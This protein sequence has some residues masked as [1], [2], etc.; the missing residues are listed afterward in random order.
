MA[1][2]IIGDITQTI[3]TWTSP[4][5]GLPTASGQG[6]TVVQRDQIEHLMSKDSFWA[7]HD[8]EPFKE[9]GVS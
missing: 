9:F 1:A 5:N 6:F 4:T 7:E 2:P 3:W 8:S